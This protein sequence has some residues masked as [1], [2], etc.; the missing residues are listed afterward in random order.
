[1]ALVIKT[2]SRKFSTHTAL[3]SLKMLW[4]PFSV[5]PENT[6]KPLAYLYLQE[7]AVGNIR[8]IF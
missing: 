7:D 3:Q 5:P 6:R 2:V 1:M 4:R 8:D